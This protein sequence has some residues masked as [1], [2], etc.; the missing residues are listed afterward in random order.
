MK[1]GEIHVKIDINPSIRD[2]CKYLKQIMHF[3]ALPIKSQS[4]G[5]EGLS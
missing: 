3:Y 1:E 5:L 4:F 2:N